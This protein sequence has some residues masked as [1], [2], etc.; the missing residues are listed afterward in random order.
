MGI[1]VVRSYWSCAECGMETPAFS[2]AT[3]V[4]PEQ[5]YLAGPAPPHWY[6]FPI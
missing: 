1:R 5:S 2:Q 6:G 4:S 3:M